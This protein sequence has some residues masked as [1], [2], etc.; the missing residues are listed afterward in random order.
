MIDLETF[1]TKL[2]NEIS[3]IPKRCEKENINTTLSTTNA[4]QQPSRLD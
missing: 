2:S 1:K 3:L 4:A